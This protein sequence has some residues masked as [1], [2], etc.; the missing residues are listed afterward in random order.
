MMMRFLSFIQIETFLSQNDF[1]FFN[2]NY[3]LYSQ[4]NLIL[5]L[6]TTDF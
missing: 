5:R 3:D 1:C 2:K 4:H 6:D